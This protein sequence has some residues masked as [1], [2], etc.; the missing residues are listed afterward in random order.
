MYDEWPAPIV[1]MA[2]GGQVLTASSA[3]VYDSIDDG[4]GRRFDFVSFSG[5]GPFDHVE[6]AAHFEL[7]FANENAWSLQGTHM[8]STA[9]L[10]RMTDKKLSFGTH[11]P[12]NE[13][14]R[15]EFKLHAPA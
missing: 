1:T 2:V 4:R 10:Q 7:L 13:I 12:G 8:P 11:E 9:M 6:E 14:S 5:T 15:G 3:A